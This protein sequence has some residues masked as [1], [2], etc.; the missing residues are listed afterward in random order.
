[1][2]KRWGGDKDDQIKV[3]QFAANLGGN[4]QL[5]SPDRGDKGEINVWEN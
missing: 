4:I 5:H 1:M 3:A 2:E